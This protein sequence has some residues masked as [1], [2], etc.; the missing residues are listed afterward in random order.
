M[1]L[2]KPY[3]LQSYLLNEISLEQESFLIGIAVIFLAFPLVVHIY[4]KIKI[5]S[6]KNR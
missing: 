2:F 6:T 1:K 5:L 4:R 3:R